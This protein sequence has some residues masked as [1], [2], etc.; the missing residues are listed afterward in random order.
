LKN[1][2]YE[3]GN[4]YVEIVIQHLKLPRTTWLLQNWMWKL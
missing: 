1:V 2:Y 4:Y 3:T